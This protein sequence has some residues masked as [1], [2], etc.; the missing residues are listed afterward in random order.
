MDSVAKMF[1]IFLIFISIGTVGY[2]FSSIMSSFLEGDLKVIWR[3]K[4]MDKDILKLNDHYVVCG[5]AKLE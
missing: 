5:A 4:R 3:K 1:S 2:L